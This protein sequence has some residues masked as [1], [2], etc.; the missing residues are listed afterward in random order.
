MKKILWMNYIFITLFI[1]AFIY[2]AFKKGY[3]INPYEVN[4]GYAFGLLIG[5][6]I[7]I[8]ALILA[9][10]VIK[11]GTNVSRMATLIMNSIVFFIVLIPLSLGSFFPTTTYT[12]FALIL[13]PF[14]VNMFAL[15][16]LK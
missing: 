15:A 4:K 3:I 7:P 10:L 2:A 5:Q 9:A 11:G 8:L 1:V 12:L 14:L 16:K 13:L 6:I